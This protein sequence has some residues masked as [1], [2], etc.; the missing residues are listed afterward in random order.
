M[1]E[2]ERA[3]ERLNAYYE[4]EKAV[5]SSQ[6]YSV[7]GKMLTRADLSEI[8]KMIKELQNEVKYLENKGNRKK[9][10]RIIPVD[11]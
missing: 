11:L 10:K 4:A 6:S 2:I 1:N 8:R 3:K 7:S 9:A 5:L